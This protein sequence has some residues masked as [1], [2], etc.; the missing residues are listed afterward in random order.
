MPVPLN[1][2][3][4]ALETRVK[5]NKPRCACRGGGHEVVV[6]VIKKV[7]TNHTGNWYY[8]SNGSTVSENWITETL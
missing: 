1:N 6:G 8:L 7:I 2:Q 3:P 4:L 5:A